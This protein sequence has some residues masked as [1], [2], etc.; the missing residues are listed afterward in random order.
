MEYFKAEIID[1]G[2]IEMTHRSSVPGTNYTYSKCPPR[3]EIERNGNDLN[4]SIEL[5]F[6]IEN[7]NGNDLKF[8][9]EQKFRI[10]QWFDI[11]KEFAKLIY[12]ALLNYRHHKDI[13]KNQNKL[14]LIATTPFQEF[15]VE[16]AVNIALNAAGLLS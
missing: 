12:S 16:D 2:N 15:E 13:E 5:N 3:I 10:T 4:V 7:H 11:K 8:T 14:S 1:L 9:N 6:V